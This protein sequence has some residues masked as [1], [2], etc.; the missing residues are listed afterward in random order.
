MASTLTLTSSR[1]P[2]APRLTPDVVPGVH[3]IEHASTNCYILQEGSAW[4][5]VDT[6]FP[7]TWQVLA[8]AAHHVGLRLRDLEAILLTHGHFDHVGFAERA[9]EELGTPVYVHPADR[10]LAEHPYRYRR[11]RTPAVYPFLYPRAV[12]PVAAMVAAGAL[13]VK[14]VKEARELTGAGPVLVPGRPKVVFSPGHTDGH[15]A[16]HLPDH[17]ALLTG[18]ALVTLD[19]YKGERGAQIIAGA[20]TANSERAL[21]SLDALRITGARVLLPG[22]GEPWLDGVEAAVAAAR[23]VGKS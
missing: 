4:T 7:A 1:R 6:A 2:G 9:I 16:L 18:D 19:P 17:D 15:C 10:H 5:L 21:A 3:R 22:H 23:A 12:G 13:R 8:R 14:G 11:E 20:A